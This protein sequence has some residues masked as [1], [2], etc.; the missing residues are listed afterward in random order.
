MEPQPDESSS[1]AEKTTPTA[2]DQP[3][4]SAHGPRGEPGPRGEQGLRGEPGPRGDQGPAGPPGAPGP[5]GKPGPQ[6]LPGPQGA[7]GRVPEP[8]SQSPQITDS[9]Q[10]AT[11]TAGLESGLAMAF[12]PV[13]FFASVFDS[14]MKQQQKAWTNVVEAA[15]ADIQNAS[16]RVAHS[17]RES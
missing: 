12:T 14:M 2:A 13:H 5:Q 15:S 9:V 4:A 1:A 17:A 6:G 16:Q 10:A 8:G 3:V 11:S 7:Q